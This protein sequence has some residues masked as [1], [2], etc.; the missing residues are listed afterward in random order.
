MRN[1][2]FRFPFVA[3]KIRLLNEAPCHFLG[4]AFY[5]FV[6]LSQYFTQYFV[7]QRQYFTC[8][9]LPNCLLHRVQ[10]FRDSFVVLIVRANLVAD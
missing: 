10:T 2:H 8:L 3:Q 5:C 6:G 1:I 9:F 4:R 7:G